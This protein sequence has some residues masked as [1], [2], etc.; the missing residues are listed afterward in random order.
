M[1]RTPHTEIDRVYLKGGIIIRHMANLD[2]EILYPS[3]EFA[4]FDREQM[5]WTITNENGFKREF[6]DGVYKQLP[7]VNCLS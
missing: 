2:C 1:D 5:K 7:K 4:N 3:G 6:K